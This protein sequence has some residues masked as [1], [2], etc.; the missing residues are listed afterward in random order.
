LVSGQAY[1]TRGCADDSNILKITLD[2]VLPI[3]SEGAVIA[4]QF[5]RDEIASGGGIVH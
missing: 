2:L 3:L 1:L 5:V 4:G